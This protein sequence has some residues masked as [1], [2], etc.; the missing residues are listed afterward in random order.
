MTSALFKAWFHNSFVRQV[1]EFASQNNLP[2]KALLLL[3]NFSGHSE[4]LSSD[5]G[6]IT[7]MFMPPKVTSLLQ[8]MDQ[9]PINVTKLF[10]RNSLLAKII[11]NS[12][13]GIDEQLKSISIKDAIM[14]L[15]P[16]WD[17][18]SSDILSNAWKILTQPPQMQAENFDAE[19]EIPSA[20]LR[21]SWYDEIVQ[22]TVDLLSI[23]DPE[24]GRIFT[25]NFYL[26]SQ[27]KQYQ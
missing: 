26:P 5:D 19:D 27:A 3:D 7:T 24:V 6:Q 10:Y 16:S 8:P 14:L 9:N 17:K 15:K 12:S 4:S 25:A 2:P 20:A 13:K 23:V 11:A 18:V 21:A 1:R 22:N